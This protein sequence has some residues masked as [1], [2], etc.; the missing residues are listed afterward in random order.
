MGVAGGPAGVGGCGFTWQRSRAADASLGIQPVGLDTALGAPP[1]G[2]GHR[3]GHHGGGHHHGGGGHFRGRFFRGRR[4]V[5]W[6]RWWGPTVVVDRASCTWMPP[7]GRVPPSVIAALA[8]QPFVN[9]WRTVFDSGWWAESQSPNAY[10][11]CVVVDSVVAGLSADVDAFAFLDVRE[12]AV[13][14]AYPQRD[15]G[16]WDIWVSDPKVEPIWV[17][18][19]AAHGY[20]AAHAE[21]VRAYAAGTP[22]TDPTATL[23]PMS[24]WPM[25][26]VGVVAIGIFAATLAINPRR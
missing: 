19:M 2:G 3:G 15:V 20:D 6:P 5:D 17:T 8:R 24:I 21:K 16:G 18:M 4:W 7:T 26:A 12:K 14:Q 9:G 22:K 13:Q 23:A 25:V 11:V 1:H 10:Y